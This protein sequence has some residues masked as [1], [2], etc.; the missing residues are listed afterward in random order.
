MNVDKMVSKMFMPPALTPG[1]EYQ[2]PANISDALARQEE[3][4]NKM[5][6]EIALETR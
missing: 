3:I 5:V 1:G 2:Q 4:K 6:D